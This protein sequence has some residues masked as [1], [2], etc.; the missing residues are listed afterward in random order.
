VA[1][2]AASALPVSVTVCG[3][4]QEV[5][6]YRPEPVCQ[7]LAQQILQTGLLPADQR[8]QNRQPLRFFPD[9]LVDQS[10]TRGAEVLEIVQLV[11]FGNRR[12]LLDVQTV[13]R[14]RCWH[15]KLRIL[16]LR[17]PLPGRH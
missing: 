14:E 11:G 6:G 9:Q 5:G 1:S 3:E 13:R 10:Q 17:Y 7:E 4:S 12:Y 15:R 16:A 2:P 8:S